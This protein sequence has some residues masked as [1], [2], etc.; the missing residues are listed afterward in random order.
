MTKEKFFDLIDEKI[1][2]H[3][4]KQDS[5]PVEPPETLTTQTTEVNIDGNDLKTLAEKISSGEKLSPEEEAIKEKIGDILA[6]LLNKDTAQ[7]AAKED[8]V[9]S[10]KTESELKDAIIGEIEGNENE[11]SKNEEAIK[12]LLARKEEIE[13]RLQEI[14]DEKFGVNT[15]RVKKNWLQRT[16]RKIFNF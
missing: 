5:E 14:Q 15:Y 3:A 12:R 11:P 16:W 10:K 4:K 7:S 6:S 2:K 8:V 1:L 9:N 13:K